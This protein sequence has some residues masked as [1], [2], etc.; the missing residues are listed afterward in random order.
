MSGEFI[1]EWKG[2]LNK[3]YTSDKKKIFSDSIAKLSN[4]IRETLQIPSY[5]ERDIE[6]EFLQLSRKKRIDYH[7]GSSIQHARAS[8]SMKSLNALSSLFFFSFAFTR[9]VTLRFSLR[10]LFLSRCH[11]LNGEDVLEGS[12]DSVNR[13]LELFGEGERERFFFKGENYYYFFFLSL[14]KLLVWL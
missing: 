10:F 11:V 2:Y 4:F 1:V 8:K 5:R 12:R 3:N 13:V 6:R 9:D 14:G 7:H